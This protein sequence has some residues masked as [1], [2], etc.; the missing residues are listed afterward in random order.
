VGGVEGAVGGV[1]G[2]VGGVDGG[3]DDPDDGPEFEGGDAVDDRPEPSAFLPVSRV[4]ARSIV[5]CQL[6]R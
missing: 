4:G 5:N 3:A 1:E 2:E 6:S